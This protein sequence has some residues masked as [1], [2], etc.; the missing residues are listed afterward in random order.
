MDLC[1]HA[2]LCREAAA[3]L[4]ANSSRE[5][6]KQQEEEL[7]TSKR[8]YHGNTASPAHDK[9]Q[10]NVE[11]IIVHSTTKLQHLLYSA[12]VC[13]STPAVPP[14]YITAVYYYTAYLVQC[15]VQE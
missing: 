6:R 11:S 14:M 10:N 9:D 4:L 7:D 1:V 12:T 13:Y 8:C 15:Y 2:D 5:L 3:K